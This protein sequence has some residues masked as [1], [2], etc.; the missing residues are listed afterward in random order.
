MKILATL[1]IL[2]LTANISLG[3]VEHKFSSDLDRLYVGGY[4]A[5]QKDIY[6]FIRYPRRARE[7]CRV[8]QSKALVF[9]NSS[10]KIDSIQLLNHI[11]ADID[12]EV[13]RILTTTS[14]NWKKGRTIEYPINFAFRIGQNQEDILGNV[15]IT[16]MSN[17]TC[18]VSS[19]KIEKQIKK[20]FEKQKF[21]KTKRLYEELLRRYPNNPV[22]QQALNSV[23]EMLN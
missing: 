18:G 3:Q 1:F 16:T 7:N 19:E 20:L 17:S 13:K 14:G 10:G 9:I 23:K 2:L 4:E 15:V 5:F 8:G 12:Q 22:Y 21:K 11:S 6:P